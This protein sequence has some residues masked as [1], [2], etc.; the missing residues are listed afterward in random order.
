MEYD[1]R[2]RDSYLEAKA[3]A[4]KAKQEY[5]EAAALLEIKEVELQAEIDNLEGQLGELQ[6]QLEELQSDIDGYASV[7][8]SYEASEKKVEAEIKA[9]AEELKKQESPP[10]AT[11]SYTWPTPS[12]KIVTS[13]YG[14]RNISYYGYTRFHNG[15]DIGA[16]MGTAVVAAD[17]GT[18]TVSTRDGGGY[19]TY[20]AI[21]H[22]NGRQTI[23]AHLSSRVAMV[24]DTVTKGQVIGY[25][26]STG[27]S[28]GPH[29]H[30]EIYINGNTVNPLQYF[31]G[32][33]YNN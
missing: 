25:S 7:I 11:G 12:C 33:I 20:I 1:K 30:F 22:G 24:G 29:L 23:Y 19:G 26:G 10:T 2:V 21:N 9:M 3:A 6:T 27:N 4:L 14:W 16:G 17:G 28:T 15:V 13:K 32:Y 8:K 5:E 18:V 31:S